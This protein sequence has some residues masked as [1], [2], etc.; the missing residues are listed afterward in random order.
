MFLRT[1]SYF[2]NNILFKNAY[3]LFMSK[4]LNNIRKKQKTSNKKLHG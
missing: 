1:L 3:D 2:C 4:K